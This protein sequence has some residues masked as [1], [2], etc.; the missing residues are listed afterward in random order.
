MPFMLSFTVSQYL[1]KRLKDL[2][3][4]HIF[5]VPGD[6]SFPITDAICHD[7]TIQWIGCSNELNA[8]YASDGYARTRGIAALCTTYG[9]GELSAY[10]GIAG[11]FS[12]NLPIIFVVGMPSSTTMKTHKLIHHTL[13]MGEFDAFTKMIVPITAAQTVLTK[14]N[15]IE[16]IQ[17]VIQIAINEKRPI[18]L[19][20]P[21]DIAKTVIDVPNSL[22]LLQR[23]QPKPMDSAQLEHLSSCIADKINAATNPLLIVGDHLRVYHAKS[24][25]LTLIEE[26]N[27]PFATMFADKGCFDE[28]HP[29][30]LGLYDGRIINRPLQE[31]IKLSDCVINLGALLTDFNTGGF[32]AHWPKNTVILMGN[33]LEMD[34][35]IHLHEHLADLIN[36]ITD[37]LTKKSPQNYPHFIGLAPS[38]HGQDDKITAAS[39]Y[40][41]WE[42][43]FKEDD[44]IIAETG[45]ISMGLG[46]AKLPKQ[47]IFQNQTLWGSIGWATPAALGA[48]IAAP[49]KRTILLTGEG[50]H[51]LTVQAL[52]QFY[53]YD[54]KPIIFVL[55]NNGYLIERLLCK[56]PFIEYNNIC[57]WQYSKLPEAFGI[58]N[59]YCA[60]VSTNAQL[61][62]ALEIANLGKQGVYIEIMT[63]DMETPPLAANLA[64][65]LNTARG[66]PIHVAPTNE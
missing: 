60:R 25:A 59:W 41:R 29:N 47:A 31:Y 54:Q 52:G 45:T 40:P 16:E 6:F 30:F 2:Q 12:A 39:L 26:K 38:H 50:S 42:S 11:A 27:L 49:Q 37:K 17:R 55:N 35:E 36:A 51:Q 57:T 8:A 62:H 24:Q 9:P 46:M 65:Q 1:V 48:M 23:T 10:C 18:Y 20:I 44:H 43:F 13:G 32:T 4:H 33:T 34:G 53:R 58:D 15:A 19:G 14:E 66:L 63:D 5:G 56:D 3:I 21:E 28:S 22:Q 7:E 61:D 64:A